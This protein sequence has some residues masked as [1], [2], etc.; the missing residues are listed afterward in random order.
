MKTRYFSARGFFQLRA[1]VAF[2]LL[3][4]SALFAVLAVNTLSSDAPA[5]GIQNGA[6]RTARELKAV[7]SS[8]SFDGDVRQLR[9]VSVKKKGRPGPRPPQFEPRLYEACRRTVATCRIA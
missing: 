6:G 4:L 1:L 7:R 8:R 5:D 9:F 2:F 3:S